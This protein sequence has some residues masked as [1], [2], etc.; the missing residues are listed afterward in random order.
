MKRAMNPDDAATATRAVTK[1]A[2]ASPEAV[3]APDAASA[4]HV[5]ASASGAPA[6]VARP[7]A[8][9]SMGFSE[10]I[11][12]APAL[13]RN[14]CDALTTLLAPPRDLETVYKVVHDANGTIAD[15]VVRTTGA[16]IELLVYGVDIETS[17]PCKDSNYMLELGAVAYAYLPDGAGHGWYALS[18]FNAA[19]EPPSPAH[20]FDAKCKGEFWDMPANA[21]HLAEIQ[22]RALPPA[23]VMTA[24]V[25]W[26]D[27][28]CAKRMVQVS[29]LPQFDSAWIDLYHERHTKK[30]GTLYLRYPQMHSAV[31]TDSMMR[32]VTGDALSQWVS[33]ADA[34]RAVGVEHFKPE[35]AHR[36][37]HDAHGICVNF[38]RV[39]SASGWCRPYTTPILRRAAAGLA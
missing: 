19:L 39:A 28:F 14:A 29:D 24:F 33:T 21:A 36:A 23:V 20:C 6:S 38:L 7:N 35:H 31:C 30:G 34:C 18:C 9:A 1:A 17:G 16:N 25:A 5:V 10:I 22:S 13:P 8:V 37:V 32:A 27:S 15:K 11:C 12:G 2:R 3:G 26:L 4:A